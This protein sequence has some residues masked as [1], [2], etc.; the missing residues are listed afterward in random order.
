MWA[1]T[2]KDGKRR[3]ACGH[4]CESNLYQ[5]SSHTCSLLSPS[6]FRTGLQLWRTVPIVNN[7]AP[8][9]KLDLNPRPTKAFDFSWRWNLLSAGAQMTVTAHVAMISRVSRRAWQVTTLAHLLQPTQRR[10]LEKLD[11]DESP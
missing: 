9:A 11:P 2:R 6:C 10:V 5:M 8:V 3:G 1:E 7:N 4:I